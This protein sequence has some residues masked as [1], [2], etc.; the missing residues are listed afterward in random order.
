MT[1][2]QRITIKVRSTSEFFFFQ[3]LGIPLIKMDK[4]SKSALK[5]YLPENPV[6][7]DCG[8]H[9]GADSVELAKILKGRVYAFEPVPD[10]YKI[11][12]EQTSAFKNISCYPLALSDK[13]GQQDFF[14]SEGGSDASSSLL[15]PQDHLTDHPDV[16]FKKKVPVKTNSLRTWAQE[17]GISK[18]DMLWLDMQGFELNMLKAAGSILDSV[19]L[20]HSE[21]S[22]KE[23][24]K[25]VALYPELR[26]FLE[27]KGFKVEMEALP[28]G[29]DMG[30][31][32]FVRQRK[33]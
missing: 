10:I 25:G 19:S 23:T 24:Y 33:N 18:I 13:D 7:I 20:I 17:Q 21:V 5:K 26:A 32:L 22:T 1:L 27:Q 29:W 31:V 2:Y 15:E 9:S 11:L 4:I 28:Q 3:R 12:I 16:F 14:I 8:A 6:I 30:N